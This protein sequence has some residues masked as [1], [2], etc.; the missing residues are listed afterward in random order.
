VLYTIGNP[1]YIYLKQ[2]SRLK[3]RFNIVPLNQIVIEVVLLLKI[4]ISAY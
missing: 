1:V 2:Q 3:S 4:L